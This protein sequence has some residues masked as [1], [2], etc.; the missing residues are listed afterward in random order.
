MRQASIH[1]RL[2]FG[3]AFT[4]MLVLGFT[5]TRAHSQA[6]PSR[7]ITIIMPIAPGGAADILGRYI[8]KELSIGLKQAVVVDNRPG[9]NDP[10][11]RELRTKVNLIETEGIGRDGAVAVVHLKNGAILTEGVVHCI[12]SV[13]RPMTDAQLEDKFRTQAHGIIDD[14]QTQRLIDFCWNIDSAA[15]I[16]DS[17]RQ[18]TKA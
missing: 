4:A 11:I 8:A 12:G 15:D 7:P 13:D 10:Q 3:L 9:A 1:H 17:Y 18:A 2:F 16:G 6:Y 14:A 5:P